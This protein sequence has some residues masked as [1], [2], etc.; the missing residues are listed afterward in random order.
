MEQLQ[1]KLNG[2]D[3]F[4]VKEAY[5][6]LRTNIQFCGQYIKVLAFTSCEENEG[7]TTVS[8]NVAKSLA[9]LGKNVLLID[10]DMRKS[11]MAKRNFGINNPVGLSELLRG[12]ETNVNNCIYKTDVP[13][14]YVLFSGSCPPNPSELLASKF[15]DT[16]LDAVK[17]SFDYVIIDTPPLGVV[18][19]AA[20]VV[21]KCDGSVL[22]VGADNIK[23]KDAQE[24]VTQ[25]RSSGTP[26]LGVVRNAA[27]IEKNKH[28]DYSYDKK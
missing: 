8:L 20:V 7:K 12:M 16:V 22:V 27:W 10:S 3:N 2:S 25:L 23:R 9:E 5:N 6:F 26:F 11:V 13:G 17:Q 18:T 21:P 15:F 1:L 14:M 28:Y 19:D 24:V 4:I